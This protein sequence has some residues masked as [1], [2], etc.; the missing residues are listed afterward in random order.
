MSVEL[1]QAYIT[2]N[3]ERDSVGLYL[4]CNP[5]L[6]LYDRWEY[7]VVAGLPGVACS[8]LVPGVAVARAKREWAFLSPHGFWESGAMPLPDVMNWAA[9]TL[10]ATGISPDLYRPL[11][12]AH[13]DFDA[14]FRDAAE[15]W[16]LNYDDLV[17]RREAADRALLSLPE[18]AVLGVVAYRP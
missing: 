15:A 10:L 12:S 1:F 14:A 11:F 7:S 16:G 8:D 2:Y 5:H 3:A 18:S 13:G 4:A 6:P 17:A 9:N